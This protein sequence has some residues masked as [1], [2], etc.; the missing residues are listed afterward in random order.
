MLDTNNCR[1]SNAHAFAFFM[2]KSRSVEK[3]SDLVKELA[4]MAKK[5]LGS[6]KESSSARTKLVPLAQLSPRAVSQSTSSGMT[7]LGLDSPTSPIC[8]PT[9][10]PTR[11]FYIYSA[12]GI[13]NNVAM[14]QGV[15]P[16]FN[17]YIYCQNDPS[18]TGHAASSVSISFASSSTEGESWVQI[19]Y[20]KYRNPGHTNIVIGI[21]V[22]VGVHGVGKSVDVIIS[23]P[24]ETLALKITRDCITGVFQFWI[25]NVNATPPASDSGIPASYW[26]AVTSMN[27]NVAEVEVELHDVR[28]H[29]PGTASNPY[30]ISAIAYQNCSGDIF[31]VFDNFEDSGEPA[32][33]VL[34]ISEADLLVYDPRN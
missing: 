3:K 16:P 29:A 23:P 8:S 19:G 24:S 31:G 10:T 15:F 27:V 6:A 34:N 28:S 13:P 4:D 14:I 9:A 21:Y 1:T 32:P 18:Y 17:P 12:T 30:V 2:K 26:A 7:R 25:D 20:R 22:E 5:R 11:H 33:V